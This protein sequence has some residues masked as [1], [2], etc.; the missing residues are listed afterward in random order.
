MIYQQQAQPQKS[1][2]CLQ[3]ICDIPPPPLSQADVWYL[4]G[5]VQETMEPPAPDFAKQ[6]YEH[7]LR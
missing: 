1:L 3:A 6:A 5:S 4:I 2:E 7:V